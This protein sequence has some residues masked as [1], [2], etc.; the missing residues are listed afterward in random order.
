MSS[1]ENGL[2]EKL[3]FGWGDIHFR[4]YFCLQSCNWATEIVSQIHVAEKY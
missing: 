2:S 1:N 3:K 4:V